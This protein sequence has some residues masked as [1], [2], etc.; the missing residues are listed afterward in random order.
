MQKSLVSLPS[1]IEH[2]IDLKSLTISYCEKLTHLPAGVRKLKA[3]EYLDINGCHCLESLPTEEIAGFNSLKLVHWELQQPDFSIKWIPP[4]HNLRTALYCGLPSV[5]LSAD[6]FQNLSS[7][8]SLNIISCPELR[9]LPLGLQHVT[10]L[11][12]LLIHSSPDL[13]DLP[14][15]LAKL[16][17]LRSLAISNCTCFMSLPEGL[18]HLNTL[19]HLS[20]QDCPHL[21]REWRKIAH[22]PRIYVGS[23][24][25]GR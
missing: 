10:T 8:R 1:E 4:S 23:L 25:C 16:S 12:S 6:S 14:D 11:Q 3:L 21:E 2:P 5:N 13:A 9:P 19:Q 7:L 20:I 17:Y 22:M 24:K 18:K 15:W